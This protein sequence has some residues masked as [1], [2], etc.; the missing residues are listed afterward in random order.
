MRFAVAVPL[1]FGPPPAPRPRIVLSE[2][3]PGPGWVPLESLGQGRPSTP[4][5]GL[6]LVEHDPQRMLH[7]RVESL[8]AAGGLSYRDAL[9]AVTTASPE[10]WQRARATQPNGVSY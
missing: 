5:G 4:P 3:S 9:R 1:R 6:S 2:H 10:L 8:A 7:E